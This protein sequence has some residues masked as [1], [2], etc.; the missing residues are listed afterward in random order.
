MTQKPTIISLF[1]YTG[2]WSRPFREDGYEVVQVDTKL[3]I[4][5]YDFD[6]KQYHNVVGILAAIPC[7][8]FSRAGAQYWK[9]KDADGR[10]AESVKLANYTLDVIDYFEKQGNLKFWVV[11]NPIGRIEKCVPRLKGKRTL[12][13][14]PCDFGDGYTKKTI[15]WGYFNP[16]LIQNPVKP[17][18][19]TVSANGRSTN[20][21]SAEVYYGAFGKE[22]RSITPM[23]FAY[24]FYEAQKAYLNKTG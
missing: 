14:N 11:E 10:T 2:N 8:D 17:V 4:D 20:A 3:G 15:L 23:G 19:Q 18:K 24:A 12:Q 6:Y 16:F 7:T 21:T 9:A 5:L 13:F 1:D 22:T